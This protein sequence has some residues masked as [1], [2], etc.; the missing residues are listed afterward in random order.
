MLRAHD[1]SALSNCD[2]LYKSASLISGINR[3]KTSR[4][5]TQ[6]FQG[7]VFSTLLEEVCQQQMCYQNLYAN[8]DNTEFLIK[9]FFNWCE[10]RLAKKKKAPWRLPQV[11]YKACY[12]PSSRC[13]SGMFFFLPRY[14]RQFS[15][16]CL[17]IPKRCFLISWDSDLSQ[18]SAEI[19][20]AQEKDKILNENTNTCSQPLFC[21]KKSRANN[22]ASSKSGVTI[23]KTASSYSEQ[24]RQPGAGRNKIPN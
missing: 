10:Q 16:F 14:S 18:Q 15:L 9:F 21:P 11:Y 1:N 8:V 7:R 20:G 17:T 3:L 24:T 12:T 23:S 6:S 2:D 5:A 4:Q 19:M 13:R 22:P